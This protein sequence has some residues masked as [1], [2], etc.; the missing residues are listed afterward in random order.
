MIAKLNKLGTDPKKNWLVP[1]P[2]CDH[3]SIETTK[4]PFQLKVLN[5]LQ[6]LN[7]PFL[8]FH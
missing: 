3:A 6:I 7:A 5:S 2:Q 1:E 8:R 4:G